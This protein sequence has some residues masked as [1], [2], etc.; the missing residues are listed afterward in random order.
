MKRFDVLTKLIK[1]NGFKIGVEMGTGLGANAMNLLKNNPDLTLI[2]V[3]YY[4]G[5]LT[6]HSTKKARKKWF[7]R[8]KPYMNRSKIIEKKS[9]EAAKLVED[10]SVDFVFIDG[11]HF[12]ESVKQ[13]IELW[14]PKVK[15]GGMISGHDYGHPDWPGVKKAVDEIFNKVSL[16]SDHVWYVFK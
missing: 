16:S 6:G 15:K 3:A 4:P 1:E 9:E 11:N 7:E 10:E 5:T 13:D 2:Q 8:I 14:R 12:Y